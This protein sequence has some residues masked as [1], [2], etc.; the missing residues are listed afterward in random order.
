MG[1]CTPQFQ[2]EH[3]LLNFHDQDALELS[4]DSD[5]EVHPNVDKRSFIRAKQAQIH[6][7][8]DQRRH[9]IKTL[10]YERIINDGLIERID[11]LLTALKSHKPSANN[12]NA[13]QLV[14]QAL[15]ESAGDAAKDTPPPPE[16]GVHQNVKEQPTY[17]KMMASLVDQ[18]KKAVDEKKPADRLDAYIEETGEHKKKIQGLQIELEAKLLELE[19]ED[20]RHITSDDIH[21][22]FDYSNVGPQITRIYPSSANQIPGR[23]VKSH[24][25][26]KQASRE[27]GTS[28]SS[29]SIQRPS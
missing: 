15:I 28:Q 26:C 18:V 29:C 1:R 17:S 12:D 25:S 22:G 4:D 3:P 21:T 11:H 5:I 8:R 13:D 24:S 16:D 23:Q 2:L 27:C 9:Q 19:K 10:K 7:Q 6:Q 20:K 14:F